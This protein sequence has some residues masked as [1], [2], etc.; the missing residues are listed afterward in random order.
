[1]TGATTGMSRAFQTFLQ[2]APEHAAAWMTAV[3]ALDAASALDAKT[4]ELIHLAV[5]GALGLESGIPLHVRLAKQAGA[6]RAEL[7][8]A[9]LVALPL[10]G[11]RVTQVLPAALDAYDQA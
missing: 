5:A 7:L 3:K 10:A 9:L 11:Q 2:E 8:S 6:T 1:M 4:E